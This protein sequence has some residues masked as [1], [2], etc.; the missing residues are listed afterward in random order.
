MRYIYINLAGLEAKYSYK[1]KFKVLTLLNFLTLLRFSITL[2]SYNPLYNYT[3]LL[4][5]LS[6]YIY[7]VYINKILIYRI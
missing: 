5:P 7:N 1:V 4:T 3:Q 2:P 6:L